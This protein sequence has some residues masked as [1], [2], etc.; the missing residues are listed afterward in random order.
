MNS[1]EHIL[2]QLFLRSWPFP[3]GVGR[4][5]IKFFSGLKFRHQRATVMTRDGFPIDVMP[6][7]HVGRVLYLTGQF[8]Q[9]VFDVLFQHSRPG[10][11]LLDIGANIGYMSACF[12]ANVEGSN[13]IAVEPQAGVLDLL[14]ANLGRFPG[15]AEIAPVALSAESGRGHLQIVDDNRG[16]SRL[17]SHGDGETQDVE[18]WS[19]EQL[20]EALK[21]TKIDIVK[22]DV[23]GHEETV[24]QASRSILAKFRPRIIVFEDHGDKA[25]PDAVIGSLLRSLGYRVHG[26]KKRLTR[27]EY[28]EIKSARDCVHRDYIAILNG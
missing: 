22:I 4:L 18:L 9:G 16:A 28:P 3:Y 13:V 26:I 25:A 2:P 15:R 12:L 24:F 20:I 7:E 19:P 14:R 11:T 1:N 23:E 17:V 10:D 6:N 5:T 21:P 8:D 27:L